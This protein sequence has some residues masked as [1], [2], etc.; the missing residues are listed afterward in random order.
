M[1]VDL[2]KLL[3][4]LPNLSLSLFFKCLSISLI[5]STLPLLLHS[6]PSAQQGVG[7]QMAYCALSQT[8]Q[9][10][11]GCQAPGCQRSAL[12][13]SYP[14]AGCTSCPGSPSLGSELTQGACVLWLVGPPAT[15]S[16]SSTLPLLL[17]TPAQQGAGNQLA[18]CAP[19]PSSPIRALVRGG[20]MLS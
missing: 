18:Y 7:N 11:I 16:I 19:S 9:H 4:Y 17:H 12:P 8:T 15:W 5:S 13:S 20:A 2:V 6:I 14:L 3:S 1:N 10:T